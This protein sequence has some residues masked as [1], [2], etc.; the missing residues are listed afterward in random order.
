VP[1]AVTGASMRLS[2]VEKPAEPDI[3]KV[4]GGF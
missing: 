3:Y 4:P 2:Y 1:P